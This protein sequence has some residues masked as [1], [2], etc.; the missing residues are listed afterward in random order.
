M[1]PPA[2]LCRVFRFYPVRLG[3]TGPGRSP[4]VTHSAHAH[5]RFTHAIP[6]CNTCEFC[7]DTL[8]NC[9]NKNSPQRVRKLNT[10]SSTSSSGHRGRSNPQLHSL[11]L[12][13]SLALSLSLSLSLSRLGKDTAVPPLSLALS[14][15]LLVHV[16]GGDSLC[17]PREGSEPATSPG[18]HKRKRARP[19]RC[20]NRRP[21]GPDQAARNATLICQT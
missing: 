11:S 3:R 10:H 7:A 13:L 20:R 12:S 8:C 6:P 17:L 2:V 21:P 4:S 15:S 18:I 14:P 16:R 5:L 1:C 19:C 9:G